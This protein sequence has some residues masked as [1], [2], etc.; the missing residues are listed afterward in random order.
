[1]TSSEIEATLKEI[2]ETQRKI[3]DTQLVHANLLVDHE[4]QCQER[5]DAFEARLHDLLSAVKSHDD[6]LNALLPAVQGLQTAV[7]DLLSTVRS[8][9]DDIAEMRASMNSLFKNMD[10]FIKGLKREDGHS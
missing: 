2:A 4:R 3:S 9:D 10:A 1:M 7:E 6:I 8:H 5:R